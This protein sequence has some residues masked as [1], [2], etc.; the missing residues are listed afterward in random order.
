MPSM[1]MGICIRC[2]KTVAL[3][4]RCATPLLCHELLLGLD[5]ARRGLAVEFVQRVKTTR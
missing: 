2:R 3:G 1:G 4:C 5:M